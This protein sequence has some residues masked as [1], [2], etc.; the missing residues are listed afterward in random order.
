MLLS[1]NVVYSFTILFAKFAILFLYLRVFYVDRTIRFGAWGGLIFHAL[2]YVAMICIEI[3]AIIQ[4][5][6]LFQ[7]SSRFCVRN[8]RELMMMNSAV[9]VITDFFVLILP[10]PRVLKLQL[11]L[12]RKI[13]IMTTFVDGLLYV[14]APSV[15]DQS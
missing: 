15:D 7:I 4:C 13:G 5:Y 6:D 1:Q 11:T 14:V 8:E 3:G 2:Y 9:N 12:K 10:I